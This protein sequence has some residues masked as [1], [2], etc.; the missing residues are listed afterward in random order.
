MQ[1]ESSY[2]SPQKVKSREVI[3]WEQEGTTIEVLMKGEP[4][5][6]CQVGFV[7]SQAMCLKGIMGIK[8]FEEN[9]NR[10][11][12]EACF[13]TCGES[14]S[15]KGN[16]YLTNSL[17]DYRSPE[18]NGIRA[19]F[20]L[21]TCSHKVNLDYECVFG[22]Y[23]RK[24]MQTRGEHTNSFE[25]LCLVGFKPGTAAKQQC[26]T[27]SHHAARISNPDYPA[28]LCLSDSMEKKLLVFSL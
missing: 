22:G 2:Y 21:E 6:D 8:D 12:S 28:I 16:A 14:L 26:Q 23:Q 15:N 3:R 24:P 20:I 19:E 7:G 13:F 9:T 5:F 17:F 18:N 1:A 27:L 10:A 25:T 4:F 11:D